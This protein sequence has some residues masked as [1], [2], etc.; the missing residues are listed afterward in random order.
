M[1]QT[2]LLGE[3]VLTIKWVLSLF[4]LILW[5]KDLS[6]NN[7]LSKL[8]VYSDIIFYTLLCY[9]LEALLHEG[10][11][12]QLQ[13]QVGPVLPVA[14]AMLELH[15]MLIPLMVLTSL[16]SLLSPCV[17]CFMIGACSFSNA[18]SIWCKMWL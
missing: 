11:K 5:R 8:A 6:T 4:S 13:V 10:T 16:T 17:F 3:A 1:M 7:F 12:R 14:T 18:I 15:E 9:S 2:L